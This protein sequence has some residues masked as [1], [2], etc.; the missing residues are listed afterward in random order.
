MK[1]MM[2][3]KTFIIRRVDKPAHPHPELP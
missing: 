1:M 2:V 3:D